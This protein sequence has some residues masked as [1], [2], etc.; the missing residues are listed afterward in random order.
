MKKV[1][2][3]IV[4]TAAVLLGAAM[5]LSLSNA[6][7]PENTGRAAQGT[8]PDEKAEHDFYLSQCRS[9]AR[10]KAE[11]PS[12]VHFDPYLYRQSV[13]GNTTT[14]KNATEPV[15]EVYVEYTHKNAFGDELPMAV[16]CRFYKRKLVWY[17][18]GGR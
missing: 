17:E 9:V 15:F 2:I 16:S 12:T 18:I 11:F 10:L 6:P 5:V 14:W 8:S 4:A 7:S 3:A 13:S 1:F